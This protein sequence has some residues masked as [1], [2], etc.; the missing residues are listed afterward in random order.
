MYPLQVPKGADENAAAQRA[1]TKLLN[2]KN[3][4]PNPIG[5]KPRSGRVS[6]QVAR[7][8]VVLPLPR[9]VHPDRNKERRVA[10]ARALAETYADDAK[11]VYVDA[12]KHQRKPK[13]YVA[14]VVRATDGKVLNACSVRAT[15]AEQAEEAAIALA[16][17]GIPEAT[18]ILSD[19][20]TAI[21]NFGRGSVGTPAASLLPRT[22]STTTHL[23][24]FPAHVG[25]IPGGAANRNEEAD[26]VARELAYRAAPP[27]PSEAD[28]ADFLDPDPLLDYGGILAWYREGRRA[29]S[30][31]HPRLGRREGVL[32]RQ[33]QTGTV[34]TP[35][36]ARHVCPGLFESAT[37]SVCA[38]E[39]ATLAHVLWGC[40]AC[41]GGT[42]RDSLPPDMEHYI[43]SP[44]HQAQLQAIQRLDAALARQKRTEATPSS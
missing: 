7:R 26:V 19:S 1:T 13:T 4:G 15:S 29:L 2:S 16:L 12:A 37:C 38:R 39:L 17:S 8:L 33:L 31:P 30:G 14:A 5:R 25:V 41:A 35:A 40:D 34:V 6:K 36:L 23:R 42:V 11:A 28:E 20:R 21:A 10:R 43:S 18:T 32:L 22:K 44:D 3:P 27:R 9:N 24:W